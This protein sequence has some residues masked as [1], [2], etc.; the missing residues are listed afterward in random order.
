MQPEAHARCLSAFALALL[1]STAAPAAE[2]G[3][4]AK[5]ILAPCEVPGLSGEARCGTYEVFE[6]R[7]KRQ[8]RK[9][10][11]KIVVL[12]ATG[13]DRAPDPLVYFA[14]GPGESAV[15]LAAFFAQ[16]FRALHRRRDV[17]L[18][19]VRGTGGSAS[20]TCDELASPKGVQG[21]L[22]DFMPVDAVRRCRQRLEKN[23]DLT[24]YTS[25][26]ATDDVAEVL[27]ALGYPRANLIGGSYGT[28]AVQVFLRRH[29]EQ[30]RTIVLE[31]VV[32]TDQRMPLFAA[33]DAQ[34][35]LDGLFTEC[36]SDADCHRAF[37]NLEAD[38]AAVLKRVSASP[39]TVEITHPQTGAPQ[40]VR[41]SR[42]G[43]AQTV[44][45]MLYVPSTAV[46]I[47]AYVHAAA[48][49]DFEPFAETAFNFASDLSQ[50]SD[51]FYLS[52]VCPEDVGFVDPAEVPAAVAGTFLGDFRARQQLAACAEWPARKLPPSVLE[53]VRSEVPALLVSGERDPATPAANGERVV[54]HLPNGLHLV[55]PD[56]SHS[57]DGMVGIDCVWDL[58]TAFIEAGNS[59][60]LDTS[61]VARI[62]R[63]PF[64]LAV[65]KAAE[66]QLAEADLARMVGGYVQPDTGTSFTIQVED[67]KL[68]AT[69]G[70]KIY[71][72][73]PQSATRF[74]IAGAPPGYALTFEVEAGRAKAV[75]LA[76]GPV[77]TRF[78]RKD[79]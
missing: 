24:R 65:P 46:A 12:P 31:G 55:V 70:E 30:V 66:V 33:R 53:P 28:R 3:A 57:S 4:A 61:C 17:V 71:V 7:E 72:L 8:G 58:V 45:Y 2:Q 16:G 48:A 62:T 60:G 26:E 39:V 25:A 69:V 38:F 47:P 19:D 41:L 6:D 22:D 18:V 5:A 73:L 40:T 21:F 54:R 15:D 79:G 44:R 68:K 35:A 20:L 32:P 76:E 43:F 56:G 51:G 37:P 1:A 49:G 27:L 11:L 77:T 50:M 23:R 34:Q 75:V 10:P 74:L 59:R 42:A 64:L 63:A 9:I 14:G 67:G 52:V 78:V 29:P 36:A 13:A